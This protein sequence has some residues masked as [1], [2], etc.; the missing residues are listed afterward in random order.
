MN[1]ITQHRC[2]NAVTLTMDFG[3]AILL[4][5]CFPSS[6]CTEMLACDK[7]TPEFCRA[8]VRVFNS[9]HN[10]NIR[11]CYSLINQHAFSKANYKLQHIVNFYRCC[12][13]R[14]VCWLRSWNYKQSKENVMIDYLKMQVRAKANLPLRVRTRDVNSSTFNCKFM[15]FQLITN[16]TSISSTCLCRE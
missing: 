16:S 4:H 14:K 12:N 1:G 10:T 11:L 9:L 13:C 7:S 8:C 3:I 6:I 15:F 5:A 2:M